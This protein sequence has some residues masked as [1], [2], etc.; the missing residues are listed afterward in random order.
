MIRLLALIS[1]LLALLPAPAAAQVYP[2]DD[3]GSQVLDGNVRLRWD[4]PVPRPGAAA[5]MSGR[6]TVIV[7]LDVSPWVGR[8]GR[9][10]KKLAPQAQAPV[11]AQWTTRGVLLPGQVRDGERTLVYSGPIMTPRL[12]DTLNVT[13]QADGD[14]MP[15]QARLVF[16]FEI[17]LES[18]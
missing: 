8:S 13:L 11:R 10:Y 15:D 16:T 18:Q 4:D 3:S 5:T 9:I 7:R 2:V 17:E 14:R 12:E 1:L 6:M